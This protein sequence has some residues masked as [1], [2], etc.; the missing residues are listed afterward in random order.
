[1][2]FAN[3]ENV[4]PAQANAIFQLGTR[5]ADSNTYMLVDTGTKEEL[6]VTAPVTSTVAYWSGSQSMVWNTVNGTST[7]WLD[8]PSGNDT[9]Q[10]PGSTIDVYFTANSASSPSTTLGQ[11][12]EINSLTLGVGAGSAGS[13]IASGSGVGSP[14]RCKSTPPPGY[15]AGTGI[16]VSSG[17]DTISA[18]VALGAGPTWNLTGG[19]FDRQ[20]HRLRSGLRARR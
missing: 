5:P 6:F 4:T 18:N 7:N 20:R 3:G 14:I 2:N 10:I 19:T 9:H 1:M 13:T 17:T 15:T 11:N 8:G 16:T 12:F